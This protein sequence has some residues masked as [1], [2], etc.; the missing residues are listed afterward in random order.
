MLVAQLVIDMT[1]ASLKEVFY[2]NF[3]NPRALI[4]QFLLPISG[5]THEF[6]IYAMRHR[7]GVDNLTPCYRKRQID[8]SLSNS[9]RNL[10][11]GVE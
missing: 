10:I 6:I 3:R 2:H 11:E 1:N 9:K 4:G 7:A 5:K 8:V